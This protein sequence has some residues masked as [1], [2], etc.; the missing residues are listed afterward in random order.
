MKRF[1]NYIIEESNSSISTFLNKITKMGYN[2]EIGKD[3]NH[4]VV[5]TASS[6]RA[7]ALETISKHIGY[8]YNKTNS[9]QSRAG[10]IEAV[11]SDGKPILI[12]AKPV[13]S[14]QKSSGGGKVDATKFE[15]NIIF[16]LHKKSSDNWTESKESKV[17]TSLGSNIN[18][19][20]EA[21]NSGD[22]VADVL[23]K[24]VGKITNA[25]LTSGGSVSTKLTKI[26]IKHGAT[27]TEA[28][29]D[30][31]IEGKNKYKCSV[32]K[33]GPSQFVSSQANETSAIFEAA[34]Q[35]IPELGP[36]EVIPI[37]NA[38]MQPQVFYRIR[39]S[40]SQNKTDF[41][42]QLSDVLG[43]HGSKSISDFNKK[44]DKILKNSSIRAEIFADIDKYKPVISDDIAMVYNETNNLGY[45]LDSA[46]TKTELKNMLSEI[47]KI[48]GNEHRNAMKAVINN[49]FIGLNEKISKLLSTDRV[50]EAIVFEAITGTKKFTNPD[51]VADYILK[52]DDKDPSKTKIF[53]IDKKWIKESAS[54]MQLKIADR[55]TGRGAGMRGRFAECLY[56]ANN[57]D[58]S[59]LTERIYESI[60][61]QDV[62][63]LNEFQ[64]LSKLKSVSFSVVSKI[65]TFITSM[66]E[67]IVKF[68]SGLLAKITTFFS[69]LSSTAPAGVAYEVGVWV[70]S[71]SYPES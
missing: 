19:F 57:Q 64:F 24:T 61:A 54:K 12:Y 69:K 18:D 29:T 25:Y 48:I 71:L 27:S 60:K 26:Y 33:V 3:P 22:E 5:Y 37:I 55:G 9:T 70:D 49:G 39:D 13:S 52:W 47:K 43:L 68:L 53:P 58:L 63:Q 16:S 15:G 45:N 62:F 59:F 8:P 6:Q 40:I 44:V 50:R 65:K 35:D 1:K 38:T 56:Y 32:K 67:N 46:K 14:Q 34:L 11:S 2:A 31:I 66:V 21:H 23:I 10:R 7:D 36:D 17:K 30:M 20:P 4:I 42:N 41:Q 51:A 28:K